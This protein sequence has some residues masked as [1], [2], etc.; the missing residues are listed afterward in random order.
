MVNKRGWLDAGI[1]KLIDLHRCIDRGGWTSPTEFLFKGCVT[2]YRYELLHYQWPDN[3]SKEIVRPIPKYDEFI[4]CS[5]Y[6]ESIAPKFR[7]PG[8]TGLVRTYNGAYNRL[9]S[10]I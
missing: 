1:K 10:R 8:E 5:R 4:D 7:T 2:N 3:L 6:I 9:E